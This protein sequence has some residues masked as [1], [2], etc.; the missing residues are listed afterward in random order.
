M[1]ALGDLQHVADFYD[2]KNGRTAISVLALRNRSEDPF[3]GV[4]SHSPG[5]PF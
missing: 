5:L 1:N 2:A 4:L 3:Y